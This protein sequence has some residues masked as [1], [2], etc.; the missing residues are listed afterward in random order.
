MESAQGLL[1]EQLKQK[2]FNAC[3]NILLSLMNQHM[4]QPQTS[5]EVNISSLFNLPALSPLTTSPTSP[6][7][8]S[9]VLPSSSISPVASP[10][11]SVDSGIDGDDDK[12][13]HQCPECL[14]RFRFKSNLFE[15]KTLHQR[16]TPFVCPFCAKTCRL[17]GNLKKHLQVHV[18]SSQELEELWKQ[19]FSR[20]SGRP[21]KHPLPQQ[22]PEGMRQQQALNTF[23]LF[24]LPPLV[25][26]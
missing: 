19:R 13:P 14:K 2:E 5:Q 3:Q 18:N 1:I 25:Q 7:P 15:H 8:A 22:T 6:S 24:S 21:R 10:S 11:S 17:K 20:S 12:R 16:S 26:I 4:I 9:T 23:N